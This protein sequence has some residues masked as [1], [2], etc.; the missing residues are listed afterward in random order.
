M[1][2]MCY[3]NNN[4]QSVSRKW[5]ASLCWKSLTIINNDQQIKLLNVEKW[6]LIETLFSLNVVLN[7]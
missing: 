3:G 4:S 2:A 1:V 7:C 5:R 6:L